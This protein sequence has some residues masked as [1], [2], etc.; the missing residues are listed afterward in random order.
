LIYR[1][2]QNAANKAIA[3]AVRRRSSGFVEFFTLWAVGEVMWRHGGQ[4]PTRCTPAQPGILGQ[5]WQKRSAHATHQ[6]VGQL[7]LLL[8]SNDA[9]RLRCDMRLKNIYSCILY[10]SELRCYAVTE[11]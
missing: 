3:G 2:A 10:C 5:N 11:K 4:G 9:L 6:S 1:I 7:A 8:I